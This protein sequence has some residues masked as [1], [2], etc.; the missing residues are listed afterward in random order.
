MHT[1]LGAFVS[2]ALRPTNIHTGFPEV[3]HRTLKQCAH[4]LTLPSSC[5]SANTLSV[6]DP[7]DFLQRVLCEN[8]FVK[9]PQIC[10]TEAFLIT[11]P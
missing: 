8:A 3:S 2:F 10:D 7:L 11:L 6:T 5:L 4:Q 9:S 1:I